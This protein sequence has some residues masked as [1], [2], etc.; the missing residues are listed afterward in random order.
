MA[1]SSE[2]NLSQ[3]NGDQGFDS[4]QFFYILDLVVEARR[5][6]QPSLGS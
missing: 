1:N 6:G 5:I 3:R 4:R 2:K